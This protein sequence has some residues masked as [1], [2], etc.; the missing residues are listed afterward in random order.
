MNHVPT[1]RMNHYPQRKHIRLRGYD[2]RQGG[3]YFCTICVHR[4][5]RR[6]NLF[7][8]IEQ[9]TLRINRFGFVVQRCWEELGAKNE[10][11]DLDAFV[12]MPNHVHLLLLLK[13]PGQTTDF[14]AQ[15]GRP[16]PGSLSEYLRAFKASVTKELGEMRGLKTLVWQPRFYD[17]VVRADKELENVRAYIANNPTNWINDRCHP[18]H[19]DFELAW[20][21]IDPDAGSASVG[22]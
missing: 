14:T 2:Y 7:A 10:Q 4:A 5:H 8:F 1:G 17:R 21:G 13:R 20:Q 6:K 11:I 22:P 12:V 19:P 18:Q 3:A 9:N 16:A 15:F